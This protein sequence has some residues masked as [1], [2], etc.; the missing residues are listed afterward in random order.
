MVFFKAICVAESTQ[1]LFLVILRMLQFYTVTIKV[2]ISFEK[3]IQ[4]NLKKE[5]I[6]SLEHLRRCWPIIRDILYS[7]CYNNICYRSVVTY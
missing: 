5:I 7:S 2:D 4:Y 1:H 6:K 3:L